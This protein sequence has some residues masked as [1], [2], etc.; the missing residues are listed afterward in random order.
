MQSCRMS[1]VRLSAGSSNAAVPVQTSAAG[2]PSTR[3]VSARSGDAQSLSM[4]SGGARSRRAPSGGARSGGADKPLR[5]TVISG[6]ALLACV[7]S[8]ATWARC[9]NPDE[10]MAVAA[11]YFSKT[12]ADPIAALRGERDAYC[13]QGLVAAEIARSMGTL[14][15]YKAAFTSDRVRTQFGSAG[16]HRGFL[17]EKMFLKNGATVNAQFGARPQV[18]ADLILVIKDYKIHDATTPLQALAHVSHIIPF[19]ELSDLIWNGAEPTTA[20]EMVAAN[21]GTRMGVLGTPIPVQATQAFL[22]GL[23]EMV[24]VMHD[25]DGNEL[26]RAPG[27]D[28]LGNPVA[29][30]QWLAQE[31]AQ[32]GQRIQMDDRVSVGAFFP[33]AT[34][35]QGMVVTVQYQGLPGDPSVAVRFR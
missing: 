29:A 30:V 31:L 28:V 8:G 20:L 24:V 12:P 25:Q 23:A 15:G 19:I 2:T 32:N 27:S 9:P 13:A 16:P 14:V 17:Y 7:A 33:A 18:V 3:A 26:G 21:L 34:P 4:G 10:V 11:A 22:D 5:R 1:E 35:A 6:L